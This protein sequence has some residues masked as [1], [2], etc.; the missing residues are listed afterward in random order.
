MTTTQKQTKY[1]EL[2]QEIGLEVLEAYVTRD[3]KN[4]PISFTMT[5]SNRF[6]LM[7]VSF[8]SEEEIHR[9]VV[10][11]QNNKRLRWNESL[12][13]DIND[14]QMNK[15]GDKVLQYKKRASYKVKMLSHVLKCLKQIN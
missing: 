9:F 6:K 10:Y 13:C 7:I 8:D 14:N 2:L 3:H 5:L 1:L 11:D 15:L 4:S 12:T